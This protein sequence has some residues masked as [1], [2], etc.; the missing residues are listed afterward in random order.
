MYVSYSL[1]YTSTD[2]KEIIFCFRLQSNC[3]VHWYEWKECIRNDKHHVTDK[4]C[5]S[6]RSYSSD[7]D[8]ALESYDSDPSYMRPTISSI[9]RSR[10]KSG[11]RKSYD[12]ESL[13][14]TETGNKPPFVVRHVGLAKKSPFFYP[15]LLK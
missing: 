6:R 10:S 15:F 12:D 3:N 9:F 1:I 11:V 13:S 2:I 7:S 4:V 8:S 5:F 14:D